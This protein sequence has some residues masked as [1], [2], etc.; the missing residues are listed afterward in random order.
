[1]RSVV[2]GVVACGLAAPM[3]GAQLVLTSD[4]RAM[5]VEAA[6][7]IQTAFPSPAYAPFDRTISRDVPSGGGN[8]KATS[9]QTSTVTAS[10]MIASGSSSAESIA[11]AGN[12]VLSQAANDFRITFRVTVPVQYAFD[13][14][15][16]GAQFRLAETVSGAV[17]LVQAS[18]GNPT[19]Y[20]FTGILKPGRNYT[21]LAQSS[22]LVNAC[23]GAS[24]S[25]AGSYSLNASYLALAPCPADLNF[26]R[27]VDD[28]DFSLFA[29]AYNE[30]L[31]PGAP[32]PCD[33]D[34]NADGFVDDADFSIF[35]A[36]YN[37][38]L[39]P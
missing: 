19:P 31:C 12:C 11:G 7:S 28:A 22:Q 26:D 30:L 9:Q 2:L 5:I 38:L 3:A 23:N 17:H 15:V 34:L 16:D 21:V 20:A 25:I 37:E 18:P 33:A 10:A 13:G 1:M 35:A 27:L 14:A 39:C 29:P 32:L 8:G 24:I 6:G 4:Q 36:A